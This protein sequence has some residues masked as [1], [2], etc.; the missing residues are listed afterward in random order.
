MILDHQTFLQS[1]IK[2]KKKKQKSKKT[3]IALYVNKWF[4][5][6]NCSTK[7]QIHTFKRVLKV[8]NQKFKIHLNTLNWTF[9]QFG[10]N[11]HWKEQIENG[12]QNSGRRGMRTHHLEKTGKESAKEERENLE[13]QSK[14]A[15]D[16]RRREQEP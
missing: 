8:T 7:I 3:D 9:I 14:K 16:R 2:L 1:K 13:S 11:K 4:K 6:I 12:K 10:R 15:H 5:C